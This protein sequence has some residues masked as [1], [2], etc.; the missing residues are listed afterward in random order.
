MHRASSAVFSTLSKLFVTTATWTLNG[1]TFWQRQGL[2]RA[3]LRVRANIGVLKIT[4]TI[5]G[6]SLL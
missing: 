6:G 2:F 1:Q 3:F 4:Y 5:L